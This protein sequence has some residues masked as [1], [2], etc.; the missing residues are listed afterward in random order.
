NLLYGY[1]GLLSFGHAAYFA[2]G[3]YA[4]GLFLK[5]VT[6]S[7]PLALVVGIAA[8]TVAAVIIGFLC[9]RL[10]E[11]YFAM[12]T[13]A[14]GMM[15]HTILWKWDAL[16][17]GADGLVNIPRPPIGPFSMESYTNYYYLTLL[18]VAAGVTLLWLVIRSSFG[19]TLQAVRDNSERVEF[20]GIAM[21]RYRLASFVISGMLCGLAGGIFAPFL[22]TI[23]PDIA[24]WTMSAQPVFMSL[25]GGTRVFFGPAVGAVIFLFLKEIISGW[26]NVWMLPLGIVLMAFVLFLRGGIV[27]FVVNLQKQ[28]SRGKAT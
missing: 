26:T 7:L 25:L 23:T 16:T 24:F 27:G 6:P 14:F 18:L 4:T 10:N 28:F 21:R 2:I 19:L 3:A 13:L 22:K 20:T 5:F 8:A 17:G 12:L 11:I 15:I 9:V 1:T